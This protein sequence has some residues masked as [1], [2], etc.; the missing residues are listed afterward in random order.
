ME[1][2]PK[3]ADALAEFSGPDVPFD[4]RFPRSR[5]VFYRYG[6]F[7][8]RAT[9]TAP[10]GN[11]EED[12]RIK[13]GGP[14]WIVNP[15]GS[16]N[17]G[18][19]RRAFL[20]TPVYACLSQRGKGGVYAA[21]DVRNM[22]AK[23][24]IIK[25]GRRLGEID[26]NGIDGYEL[27][28]NESKILGWLGTS[29]IAPK[30]VGQVETENSFYV[31]EEFISG[32][33]LAE[34]IARRTFLNNRVSQNNAILWLSERL[35][36]LHRNRIVWRDLKPENIIFTKTRPVFLDFESAVRIPTAGGLGF[37]GT[38]GFIPPELGSFHRQ[39][40]TFAQDIYALGVTIGLIIGARVNRNGRLHLAGIPYW[41]KGYLQL[42]KCM[43][44]KQTRGRP[45]AAQVRQTIALLQTKKRKIGKTIGVGHGLLQAS[46]RYLKGY[47]HLRYSW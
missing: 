37:W 13:F 46:E 38:K 2:I 47:S 44:A 40:Q 42:V 11:L 25:E 45:T 23:R 21:I 8:E 27:A 39:N 7:V 4:F 6:S 12:K 30:M 18:H 43:T 1:I 22:P 20:L 17:A 10:N 24:I 3:L 19:D 9:I 35:A 15:F 34:L 28:R 16:E 41:G 32:P 33:T 31:L 14:D 5:C 26:S 29:G 36:I